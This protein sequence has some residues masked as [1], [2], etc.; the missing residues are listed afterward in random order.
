VAPKATHSTLGKAGV[1]PLQMLKPML[2]C[3]LS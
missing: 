2:D 1:A 3:R